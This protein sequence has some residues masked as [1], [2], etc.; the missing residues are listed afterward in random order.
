[1]INLSLYF[2]LKTIKKNKA[3]P[4]RIRTESLFITNKMRCQLRHRGGESCVC[5]TQE[6]N[7]ISS[8]YRCKRIANTRQTQRRFARRASLHFCRVKYG[9]TQDRTGVTGVRI[10]YDT[11]TLWDHGASLE[12]SQDGR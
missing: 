6:S 4:I 9:P 8:V 7:L 12:P 3:A 2:V 10:L 11:A 1:M 5:P